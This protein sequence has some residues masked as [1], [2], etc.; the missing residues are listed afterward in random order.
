[1]KSLSLRIAER[2]IQSAKPES[3]LA[4]RAVMI[5]HRSEIEDAVQRGCSLLSIWKTLSEEGVINFGYQAFRRYARV[6]IN[7]DNKTH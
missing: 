2:V 1:M 5:I 4:H 6:L 3:S 7:A